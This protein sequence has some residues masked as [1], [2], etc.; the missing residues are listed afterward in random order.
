M[1]HPLR[2]AWIEIL[3][4]SEDAGLFWSHPLRGAWIEIIRKYG[5]HSNVVVAPLAGC[6]D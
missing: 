3:V 5:E 1:S 2:G 4:L 6:V